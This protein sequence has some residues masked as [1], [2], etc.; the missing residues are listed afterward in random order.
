M[1]KTILKFIKKKYKDVIH[2]I[3]FY[4]VLIS[5]S[6]LILA[7]VGLQVEHLGWINGLKKDIPY[8]FIEDYETARSILSTIISGILSLTVFS[9]TMVMVVL[10]QASSNFS[11]RLLPNLIS[12]KKHQI[13]LGIYI[14]TL[15]YCIFVL[16]S[17]GAYGI[18]SKSLGLSTMIAAISSFVCIGLF[19]YFI[20]S[21]SKAIQIHNIID[22]IYE[23]SSNYLKK[24]R[25]T[26]KTNK[27]AH[28]IINTE[29]WRALTISKTGYFRGFDV[30]LIKDSLIEKDIQIE[31]IP[32]INQHIWNGNPILKIKGDLTNEEDDNLIFCCSISSDRHEGDRGITGMIKLMEIAVKAM[33]PGINDPGTAIDA[34]NK[35]GL[36]LSE[37]LQFPSITSKT[38]ANKSLVIV[39]NSI[40]A[41]ELMRILIQPIRL[42]SKQDNSVLYVLIKSLQFIVNIPSISPLNKEIVKIEL[43]AL[44][45]DIDKNIDN[46]LDKEHLMKLF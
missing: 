3:A 45:F 8:L 7:I 24:R 20:D 9:F 41:K 30:S 39:E 43:D 18:D 22:R 27:A 13:I 38:V 6:F 5:F 2:S 21:I 33:S 26:Q 29:N 46:K 12:N 31:I 19:V 17:L 23:S 10:N 28:T 37:F 4:P 25:D 11:P 40:S 42:Y 35:I 1:F 14:G 32:Y 44:A 34:I 16:I 15:L 36:L